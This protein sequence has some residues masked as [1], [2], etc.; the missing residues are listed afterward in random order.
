MVKPRCDINT[1]VLESYLHKD[2]LASFR[3]AI[4]GDART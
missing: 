3:K 4:G 2:V 1:K